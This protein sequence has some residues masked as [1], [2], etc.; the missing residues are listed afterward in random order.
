MSV[1]DS[2]GLHQAFGLSKDSYALIIESCIV[3]GVAQVAHYI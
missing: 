1:F 2:T 3:G